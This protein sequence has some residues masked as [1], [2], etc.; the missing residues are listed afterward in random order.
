ML[1]TRLHELITTPTAKTSRGQMIFWFCLSFTFAAIYA[2][3]GLWKAFDGEYVVQDDARQHVFWMVRFLDPQL[4][5]NDLIADYFQSV[6]P[7][8]YTS[9][10]RLAAAAGINPLLFNK[11]LPPVLGLIVTGYC[12][13]L[14]LEIF[15]IPAAGFIATLLFNQHMGFKDDIIS[16]TPRAFA[17][18][19]LLAFLYYLL[20]GKLL[21]TL[22]AIALLGLFYPQ[23]LLLCAA[24]L[25]LRLLDWEN[26]KWG[27]SQQRQDYLFCA[28]VLGIAC[29]LLLP[30]ALSTSEYGPVITV[31]EAKTLP[32]FWPKGRSSFFHENPGD[33]FLFG[34]RSGMFPKAILTPVTLCVG[35]FLPLLLAFSS[36]FPKA[37]QLRSGIKILPQM[38]LASIALFCAAHALLF[39][40]HLPS[41][42]TG[43]SFRVVIVLASAIAFTL[44][45]DSVFRWA[46]QGTVLRQ[47]IAWVTVAI[48]SISL[49]CYPSFVKSFPKASYKHGKLPELYQFFSQQPKNILIAS[50]AEEADL[51][52]SFTQRSVLVAREYAI[53]YQLGYY[54]QFR[55]RLLDLVQAQYSPDLAEVQ[56][57]I[58]TYG[59]DFILLDPGALTPEYISSR[60]QRWIRKLPPAQAAIDNM[61]QG[62]TP[63][64]AKVINSYQAFQTRGMVVLDANCI[65]NQ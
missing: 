37:L 50:I 42:Y 60:R 38:L 54:R 1:L 61:K 10:Y 4:F 9:L 19:L 39:K 56:K 7:A 24:I 46:Q 22:G 18:P 34:G 49:M 3:L 65:L 11:L 58:Q 48:V 16:A 51:L 53:P 47:I 21:P 40:L 43:Y 59:V 28:A 63:A 12:F 36:R 25:V 6:A 30:F 52:P 35:L 27:F 41:R 15:P 23:V 26:G 14:C 13:G 2:W 29:A 33:F 32:E 55:Q 5:P 17:Y 8:G 64:L 62:K 20:R 45:L 31:A 44:I 57:F